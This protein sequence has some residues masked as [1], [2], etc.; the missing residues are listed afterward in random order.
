MANLNVRPYR[1]T[2]LDDV[3]AIYLGAIR[4]IASKDYNPA[5]IAAW[6]QADRDSWAAQ[7][8][9]RTTWVAEINLMLVGWI[10]IEGDGHLDMLYVH[11]S[12]QGVGIA[13]ALLEFVEIAAS[14]QGLTR[15]HTEASITARIFFEKRG[16]QVIT[17]EVVARHG[18]NFTRF[19]MQKVLK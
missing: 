8:L 3:I 13:S 1:S 4:D 2:D 6:A 7:R 9:S 16:F 11:P 18:Q 17:S 19:R 12:H 10:G 15:I 5:E 14:C